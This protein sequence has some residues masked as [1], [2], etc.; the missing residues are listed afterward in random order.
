MKKGLIALLVLV[1]LVIGGLLAAPFLIPV[2]TYK[3][4]VAQQVEAATGRALAIDGPVDLQLLP[5]VALQAD[6]VRLANREG[7]AEAD[8]LRLEALQ[9]ELKVL[10]LL[11]GS[12][13]IDRFVLVGPAI[14]LEVDAEG[15]PNWQFGT[16]EPV[17]EEGA[18]DG[19]AP[20]GGGG[21]GAT[22][23]PISELKLGDI[24][25]ENGTLTYR[26]AR[27]GAN[28]RIEGINLSL[29][30]PDLRGPLQADG[31]LEYKDRAVEI[32]LALAQ[33]L[34]LVEGGSSPL[35]V[36][37]DSEPVRLAF[38]GTVENGAV[39]AARGAVDLDVR[40][41]RDLAA[42]LTQ[43]LDFE[44][45]GFRQLAIAGELD[46]TPTR[47][48]FADAAIT[49]DDITA[50]GE[51]S[52]DLAGRVPAVKGRLEVGEVDLNPYLPEPV[53]QP[54]G[55]EAP[56]GETADAEA[57][58]EDAAA[59]E[60][61]GGGDGW[62]DEPIPIPTLDMAELDFQLG[63]DKLLVRDV[64]L[65]RTV[66]ALGLKDAVLRADLEEF[67]LYGGSGTGSFRLDT[68]R[69]RPNVETAFQLEGLQAAPFLAA[70]AEFERLEGTASANLELTTRGRSQRDFVR[71]LNGRGEVLFEDGAIVGIN[72][73]QMV[74]N[75]GAAFTGGSG[76]VEKTDFAELGGSFRIEDGVLR[77]DDLRLQA[78]VLR[79]AGSGTVNLK[80]R[81]LDY[82]VEP[83]AAATLEGQ[84]GAGDVAG[85]LVPVNITGT[86]EDPEFKPDLA[87]A[88]GSAGATGEAVKQ[89]IEQL[90]GKKDELEE[91]AKTAKQQLEEAREKGDVKG[92]VEGVSGLLG[93]KPKQQ[94]DAGEGET[95]DEAPADPA[96]QLL[97][98]ILRN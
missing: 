21:E 91:A 72:L 92:L 33:P 96:Q 2:D 98:G 60:R 56:A 58:G 90:E 31:S 27:S 13:E 63:L 77:N 57:G 43:P 23:L 50:E 87:A 32:A 52:A 94:G 1:V 20:A 34:S 41:I 10:P 64:Q 93:N 11:T 46:A 36:E 26:D 75:I 18:P 9:V 12:V 7:A 44:G 38:D 29:D 88:L 80:R 45:E 37:V 74:R 22:T 79:L 83:K 42:W 48:T 55:D 59:A 78:P 4:Q 16:G 5:T 95:A 51:V 97:K 53:E 70:A 69:K 61:G 24:R 47:I 54:A 15:R 62:S 76:E 73:A 89:Q 81:T 86:F 67:G 30:L 82:R 49:F 6:Q 19:E 25:I 3:R 39:P 17:A 84:G 68:T 85:I 14:H 66:L 71:F 35:D 40:A 8:M 28:E 65:D